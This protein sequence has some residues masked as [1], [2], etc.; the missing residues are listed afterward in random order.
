MEARADDKAKFCLR[1][2]VAPSEYDNLYDYEVEAFVRQYN[3]MQ[4]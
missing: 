4:K 1:T 2:G 3:K